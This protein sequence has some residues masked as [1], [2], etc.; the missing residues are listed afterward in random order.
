[1][2]FIRLIREWLDWVWQFITFGVSIDYGGDD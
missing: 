2:R 1:M